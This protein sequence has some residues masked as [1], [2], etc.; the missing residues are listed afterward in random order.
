MYKIIIIKLMEYKIYT[1]S[2]DQYVVTVVSSFGL[3]H[4]GAEVFVLGNKIINTKG[5]C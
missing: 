2:N 3:G 4:L 5:L 1:A